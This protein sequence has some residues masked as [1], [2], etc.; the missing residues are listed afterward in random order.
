MALRHAHRNVLLGGLWRPGAC[1]LSGCLTLAGAWHSQRGRLLCTA[2]DL[3]N[4][5][6]AAASWPALS[7]STSPV[8]G[9]FLR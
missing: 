8:W 6:Q 1:C 7:D 4:D 5:L 3:L 2:L 9:V